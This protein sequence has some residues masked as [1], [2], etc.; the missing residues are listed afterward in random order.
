VTATVDYASEPI[1]GSTVVAG[2][3]VASA[4]RVSEPLSPQNIGE[5]E[6]T[7]AAPGEP[8]LYELLIRASGVTPDGIAYEREMTRILEVLPRPVFLPMALAQSPTP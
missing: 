5:Y 3:Q 8:G 4:S 2:V 1:A 6:G 7:L